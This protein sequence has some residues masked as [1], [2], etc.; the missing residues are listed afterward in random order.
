MNQNSTLTPHHSIHY[1]E[2]AEPDSIDIVESFQLYDIQEFEGHGVFLQH[3]DCVCDHLF[4]FGSSFSAVR[5]ARRL[6]SMVNT[7]GAH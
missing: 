3:R 5:S 6:I 2:P 7:K 4:L 1:P